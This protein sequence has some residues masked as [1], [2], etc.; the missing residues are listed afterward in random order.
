MNI[1]RTGK[2][3]MLSPVFLYGLLKYKFGN[4]HFW[5]EGYKHLTPFA[6]NL[7]AEPDGVK[8]IHLFHAKNAAFHA[9]CAD[10]FINYD[11]FEGWKLCQSVLIIGI[12]CDSE[13]SKPPIVILLTLNDGICCQKTK[14]RVD[15]YEKDFQ[16]GIRG[17]HGARGYDDGGRV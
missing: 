12:V 3:Q 9:K 8:E 4:R 13:D 17:G 10:Q 15:Y 2:R 11:I 1:K 7:M 5:S 14:G 16:K 6:P